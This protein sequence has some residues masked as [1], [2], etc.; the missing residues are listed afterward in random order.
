M[1]GNLLPSQCME[2]ADLKSK[3]CFCGL[4]VSVL[5]GTVYLIF[6]WILH[7]ATGIWVY[8][9]LDWLQASSLMFYAALPV[10]LLLA[11]GVM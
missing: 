8:A 9:V 11:F 6:H 4:Q 5:Y 3:L 1:F 10:L 7:A 2:A